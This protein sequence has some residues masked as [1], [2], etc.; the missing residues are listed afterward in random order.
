MATSDSRSGETI[1]VRHM[2]VHVD[3]VGSD[4]FTAGSRLRRPC[5]LSLTHSISLPE[6]EHLPNET[7]NG[8][9]HCHTGKSSVKER[10]GISDPCSGNT[11]GYDSTTL[12]RHEL[13]ALKS[14]VNEA[15]ENCDTYANNLQKHWKAYS[16]CQRGNLNRTK[17]KN[18]RYATNPWSLRCRQGN[19]SNTACNHNIKI[20]ERFQTDE[21][22]PSDSG[23]QLCRDNEDT[24]IFM[25]CEEHDWADQYVPNITNAISDCESLNQNQ[26][27]YIS[28]SSCNSSDGVLVNFSAIFNKTNNAVPATP[29]DLD[30]PAKKSQAS[31]SMQHDD[32][33]E[34]NPCWS[35]SGVDPNCNIYQADCHLS[36]PAGLSSQEIS[37]LSPC[38][39]Q[40]TTYTNNYYK[41]VTCDLSSQSANSPAWSSLTSCSEAHSNGSMT[42]PTEYFLFEKPETEYRD[43]VKPHERDIQADE[44]TELK[45]SKGTRK[46]SKRLN[47]RKTHTKSHHDKCK[48]VETNSHKH[49]SVTRLSQSWNNKPCLE[50][51]TQAGLHR[52]LSCPSQ[53]STSSHALK[54]HKITF[55]ELARYRKNGKSPSVVKNSKEDIASFQIEDA[56][57][58]KVNFITSRT[59]KESGRSTNSETPDIPPLGVPES[60]LDVAHNTKPQR[61]T[62]LPIQPFVLEPPSLKQSSKALGSLIDHYMSHKHSASKITDLSS[63]LAPVTLDAYSSI[64]LKVASCSDTCST[65][66]PT[67]IEP[68]IRPHWA[69]PSP[70]F[71]QGHADIKYRSPKTIEPSLCDSTTG[72]TNTCL[73]QIN[74]SITP[75]VANQEKTSVKSFP[76]EHFQNFLPEQASSHQTPQKCLESELRLKVYPYYSSSP[77]TTSVTFLTSDTSYTLPGAGRSNSD[78]VHQVRT[79]EELNTAAIYSF[80]PKT[81]FCYLGKEHQHGDSSTLADRPP[82][83][84]CSSP[85]PSTSFHSID[86]LQRKDMLKSLSAAVDLITAHF[87]SSSD[88]NEKFRLGNSLLCPRISQLVLDQLCPAIRDVLQDGL[89]PFKLDLIV[90]QRSNKPWSVVEAAT[91]PGPSTRMLHSLVSVV[92]KC[93]MLTNHS[94]RLNAFFL[95]LLNLSV[96][97][98]W[99]CH[100]HTCED[101]IAEYYHP[102]AFLAL[103]QDPSCKSLFQEFLL[104]MQPLS[105]LPFDLHLLSESRLQ[106]R[107]QQNQSSFQRSRFFALSGYSFLRT[108]N[109]QNSDGQLE[110]SKLKAKKDPCISSQTET[111]S[112]NMNKILQSCAGSISKPSTRELEL[113][114][115]CLKKNHAGWWLSQTPITERVMEADRSDTVPHVQNDETLVEKGERTRA[116][117]VKPS[118]RWAR[119]F[120]SGAGVP[121]AVKEA[122]QS[123][124]QNQKIRP[125]SQWLQL[126]V[127]KMD[128]LA[129]SVWSKEMSRT[130]CLLQQRPKLKQ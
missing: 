17:D 96:L 103:S 123:I 90:G 122:Q 82:E 57:E 107:T 33:L 91:Q 129:Q 58:Q 99:F 106:R 95:G 46:I 71:F 114:S 9:F 121:V 41:L 16:I 37:G 49:I 94:M 85:D 60:S 101:V 28:D 87:S 61:P 81:I 4:N 128:Q 127:S 8:D 53:I 126:G 93:S 2:P 117:E 5:S 13:F 77:A 68:Y 97:E 130:L 102:W 72:T 19:G 1:I 52:V 116:D 67:P 10:A 109:W 18:L 42:P 86:L 12:F 40:L 31:G 22:I 105:E 70:L 20:L 56:L 55:A 23:L 118:L 74:P 89:R 24:P 51:T 6:R 47:K 125:P 75:H 7:L 120:G 113:K 63:H 62:S 112:T 104:L 30:S 21:Q 76:N 92:K 69:P 65:C 39:G 26:T 27:D 64:H 119:L 66:T 115:D 98:S 34:L 38:Q 45:R 44:D 59:E 25:D 43:E 80:G 84:F 15:D 111:R 11:R 79:T 14:E 88:P 29:Y 73:V 50:F 3:S 110:K 32:G 100:L 78:A 83:E 35:S 36:Y 54:Q 108:I 124:K 48:D